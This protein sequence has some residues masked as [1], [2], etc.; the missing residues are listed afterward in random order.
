MS[1]KPSLLVFGGPWD[2][3]GKRIIESGVKALLNLLRHDFELTCVEGDCDFAEHVE[4]NHP[5]AI[6]FMTG[7]ESMQE[8]IRTIRNTDRFPEIPRMG[9]LWRDPVTPTRLHGYHD[10]KA[11][12]V[13]Q[14]FT[15]FRRS[16]VS[17][18]F[19]DT[20]YVPC[21]LNSDNFQ[22][23]GLEKIIPVFLYGVGWANH[24]AMYPWRAKVGTQLL[25]EIPT[26]IAP[27]LNNSSNKE[28]MVGAEC[29]QMLNRSWFSAGCGTISHTS[30]LRMLEIPASRCCLITEDI[31]ITRSM[32][33]E[34]GVNCMMTDGDGITNRIR[35]LLSDKP[36]LMRI[37]DAG[38]ELIR[39]RHGASSRRIFREYYDLVKIKRPD[40]RIAQPDA[41]RPLQLVGKDDPVPPEPYADSPLFEM[42]QEGYALFE[43]AKYE[44]A[45]RLFIEAN[46][47]IS[48]NCE[49]LIG[50]GLCEMKLNK[51]RE[52]YM[53]LYETFRFTQVMHMPVYD[54]ISQA[55]TGIGAL[56]IG[57]KIDAVNL[58][59]LH[60]EVRHPALDAARF[61]IA[62][63]F[64]KLAD[65]PPFSTC[66]HP[67]NPTLD[68][69]HILPERSFKE[70]A[71]F[72]YWLMKPEASISPKPVSGPLA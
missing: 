63:I 9:F 47:H 49:S 7:F 46:S 48:Y 19:K 2:Y 29:G 55:L 4:K 58:L 57:N 38:M 13:H 40:Q 15:P 14:I 71:K 64:T 42:I 5:D 56:L 31:K 51:Y 62:S 41:F 67:A 23:Y 21:W 25:K 45:L 44:D 68:T 70:W 43:A 34:D 33:F 26:L 20:F 50:I 6:L 10:L 28:L 53:A 52:A 61:I 24:D 59:G 1:N 22:D 16:E 69:V 36:R 17:P 27:K 65:K 66:A 32:G 35:D 54:P 30:T 39:T 72:L 60:A 12:G 11:W 18:L 37:I 8:P 3:L